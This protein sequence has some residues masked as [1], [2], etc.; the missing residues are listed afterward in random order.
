MHPGGGRTVVQGGLWDGATL[1][2]YRCQNLGGDTC[3]TVSLGAEL[4]GGRLGFPIIDVHNAFNEYNW[5]AM[6]W[7]VWYEWPSGANFTFNSYHNWDT[8][9]IRYAKGKGHFLYIKEGVT[10][11]G[12]LAM[13]ESS[14]GVLPLIMELQ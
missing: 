10:Q 11:G 13:I 12:P 5:I 8:L 14:L 6:L 2:W 9:V 1:H 3:N 7:L 4:S